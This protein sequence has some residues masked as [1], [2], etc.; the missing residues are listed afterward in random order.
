VEEFRIESSVANAQF[1][2]GGGGTVNLTFKSGGRDYHGGL[3][4]FLRHWLS[5]PGTS[6][7]RRL[8]KPPFKL[9]QFGG[10]VGGRLNPRSKDPKTFFFMDYQGGRIRQAQSY[11]SNVPVAAFRNGDF[12]GGRAAGV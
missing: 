10:F 2:R 5:M 8:R 3:F 9:N 12:L 11:V 6:S 4:H 7:M 1:G